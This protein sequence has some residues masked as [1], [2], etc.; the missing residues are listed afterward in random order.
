MASSTNVSR[1]TMGIHSDE[2][3]RASMMGG[4]R[5]FEHIVDAVKEDVSLAH[6]F[7]SL[8]HI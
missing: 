6:L 5:Y 1:K 2:F 7:L 8:I 4:F 3:L